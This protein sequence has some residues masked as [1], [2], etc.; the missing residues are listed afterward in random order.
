MSEWGGVAAAAAQQSHEYIKKMGP[1]NAVKG[2]GAE[3]LGGLRPDTVE[4]KS[5]KKT[6]IEKNGTWRPS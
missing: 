5:E 6:E 4:K 1:A 3:G 2:R